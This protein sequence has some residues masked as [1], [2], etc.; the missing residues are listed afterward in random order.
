MDLDFLF[1]YMSTNFFCCWKLKVL[2]NAFSNFG[3]CLIFLR[4]VVSSF[5]V[6]FRASTVDL[7]ALECG[8]SDISAHLLVWFSKDHTCVYIA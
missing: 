5:L 7:L 1:L 3:F 6:T 8:V 4:V 2:N